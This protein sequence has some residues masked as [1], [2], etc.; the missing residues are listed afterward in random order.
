LMSSRVSSTLAGSREARQ[1][2]RHIEGMLDESA[3][4]AGAVGISTE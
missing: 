4:V 1:G 2:G 3:F